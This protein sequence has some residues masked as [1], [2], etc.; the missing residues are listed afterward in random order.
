[1][2]L[3]EAKSL[4]EE[5]RGRF[6]SPFSSGD[7]ETIERLYLSVCGKTFRPTSCQQCYHDALIEIICYIKRNGK[8]SEKK[9]FILK[10][11]A[12][13][14]SPVFENGKVFT[15]D[16]LTD[17]V[18]MRYL[19]KFPGQKVLFGK[20]PEGYKVGDMPKGDVPTLEEAE[21]ML[22]KAESVLAGAKTKVENIQKNV[23]AADTADKKAK[24]EKA[25]ANAQKAV[26]KAQKNVD[27][28]A[29]LVKELQAGEAEE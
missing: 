11:G 1:M 3:S 20:F 17:E 10:A 18:A 2:E 29:E 24:A 7:K 5:L 4:I 22:K 27:E 21:A 26:E 9:N 14:H 8:M 19:A 25:L 28:T 16:N 13:I 15:N 12:I 6:D 23:A